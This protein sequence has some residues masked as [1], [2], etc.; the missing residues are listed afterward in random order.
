MF[1]TSNHQENDTEAMSQPLAMSC[2]LRNPRQIVFTPGSPSRFRPKKPPNLA[3]QR[4]QV[5]IVGGVD[6]GIEV[7]LIVQ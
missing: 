3:I 1:E 7:L 5:F 4:I 6:G 2:N